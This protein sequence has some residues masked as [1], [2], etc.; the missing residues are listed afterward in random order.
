MNAQYSLAEKYYTDD[1]D[2]GEDNEEQAINWFEKAADQ[3]HTE[4]EH[5]FA[6][7]LKC[8]VGIRYSNPDYALKYFLSSAKKGHVLSMIELC[9]M[10]SRELSCEK[11]DFD[12]AFYWIKKA[13][14]TGNTEAEY[15]LGKILVKGFAM[16]FGKDFKKTNATEGVEWLKKA[17]EKGYLFAAETLGDI[18]YEGTGVEKDLKCALFWY[19]KGGKDR[20]GDSFLKLGEISFA[21]GDYKKAFEYFTKADRLYCKGAM[22]RLG[23]CYYRGYGVEQDL[24]KA[25]EYY[26]TAAKADDMDFYGARS[27]LA[28]MYATD[29]PFKNDREAVIWLHYSYN[30][31]KNPEIFYEVAKRHMVGYDFRDKEHKFECYVFRKDYGDAAHYFKRAAEMGHIPSCLEYAKCLLNGIGVKADR[32]EAEKWFK[33]AAD[34]GSEEA[35]KYLT[36]LK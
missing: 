15:M 12:K 16:D 3:G 18:Y 19:E 11:W 27:N 28:L 33:K 13:A 6:H 4:A 5:M 10:Y 30:Y 23:D 14:E 9:K 24:D 22:K 31:T 29:T 36:E 26:I 35:K 32:D 17:A 20:N 1:V 2:D 21:D 8:G 7:C 25:L 34:G